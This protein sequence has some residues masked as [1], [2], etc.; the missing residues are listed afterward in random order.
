MLP[1]HPS[2][3]LLTLCLCAALPCSVRPLRAAGSS[4]GAGPGPAS[5]DPAPDLTE[6]QRVAAA[7]AVLRD[8]RA[9]E[10]ARA[11]AM[12]MLLGLG[13]RGP[14]ALADVLTLELTRL[15]RHHAKAEARVLPRLA[16]V[17]GRVAAARLDRDT[18]AALEAARRVVRAGA[19]DPG[20]TKE[21]IRER[22]DPAYGQLEALLVVTVNQCFDADEELF[23]E[24]VAL[25]DGL[26][27]ELALHAR[28][29]AA[30]A[31]LEAAP[32]GRRI[33][34][35]L[36]EPE[37]PKR[38][39]DGLLAEAARLAELGTPMTPRDREVFAA[40]EALGATLDREEARGIHALQRR[41][42]LL[43]LPAQRIDPKLCDACRTHSRDM[44]EHGF[45]AHESPVP[46][47]KTPWDRAAEAGTSAS[48]ENIASGAATGSDTI[49]QWWYSPG[50]HKNM[51]G[52]G[53][54]TG[55]GRHQN[56]WTQ[57][58]GE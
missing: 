41:R 56:H 14:S 53:S 23:T 5:Q 52:G 6:A 22:S 40:N 32:E 47:R 28:F 25:L 35:G 49:L 36:R 33:A 19:D 12:D 29:A 1:S 10:A 39:L 38:D 43:G 54:R 55:L 44:V 31:A 15:R 24:W 34:A 48:A 46:G 16:K 50:H 13:V 17:A 45:F 42:V 3:A 37:R 26:E 20:L 51:L 27:A 57:L 30:R 58:F 18:L 8:R 11:T 21:A 9:D 7:V 4:S 2:L